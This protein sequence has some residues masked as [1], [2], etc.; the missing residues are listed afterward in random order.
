[1]TK[2]HLR[3]ITT[4][5]D[6]YSLWHAYYP[7]GGDLSKGIKKDRLGGWSEWRVWQWTGSGVLE[8]STGKIDRNWLVGGPSA[9]REI[10]V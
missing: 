6:D 7:R 1:M 2:Y 3:G 9:F 10:I 4:G 8:G 5:I